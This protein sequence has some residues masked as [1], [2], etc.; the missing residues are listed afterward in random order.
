MQSQLE[1]DLCDLIRSKD[2]EKAHVADLI[3]TSKEFLPP[4]SGKSLLVALFCRRSDIVDLFL[5]YVSEDIRVFWNACM[6]C[7]GNQVDNEY[8]VAAASTMNEF[9]L[10]LGSLLLAASGGCCR[11]ALR[12]LIDSCSA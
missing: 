11:R 10:R 5:S 8:I 2:C 12:D 6:R 7:S 9:A 1:E 4:G 3:E